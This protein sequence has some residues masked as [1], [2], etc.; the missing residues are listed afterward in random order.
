MA[1]GD[2]AAAYDALL[3]AA[4]KVNA[5]IA[6]SKLEQTANQPPG[7]WLDFDVR[8]DDVAAIDAA[9]AGAGDVIGGDVTVALDQEKTLASKVQYKIALTSAQQLPPRET[10]TL[11]IETR[12]VDASV[13]HVTK[14]AGDL[15]GRVIDLTVTTEPSGRTLARVT[16]DL[17]LDKAAETIEQAK[18]RGEVRGSQSVRHATASTAGSLSRARLDLTFATPDAIVGADEGFWTSIRNG[19][20]TSAAGLMWSVKLIVIGACLIAPW[21]LAVWGGWKVAQRAKRSR[22]VA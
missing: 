19:L 6:V 2:V 8:R 22:A 18:A 16:I 15:G 4:N 10:T 17:P 3:R 14:V 21:A 12:N 5:R 11:A 13:A 20:A 9:I 7:A 1:A